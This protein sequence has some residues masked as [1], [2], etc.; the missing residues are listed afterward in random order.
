MSVF[1]GDLLLEGY[2]R[3]RFGGIGLGGQMCFR[4]GFVVRIVRLT[5]SCSMIM[6]CCNSSIII[7]NLFAIYP[8]FCM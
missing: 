5:I 2:S 4:G 6:F 1:S 3:L 8:Y 7:I